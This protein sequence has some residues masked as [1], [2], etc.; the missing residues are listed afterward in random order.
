ML[1]G[2]GDDDTAT[3]P[4][5]AP[6]PPPPP[7]APEPEP[8]PEPPAPEAPATPTGLIVS[9][10]SETSITW[11]WD[12]VEGATAYAV[13]ASA[14]EMFDATD[15]VHVVLMPTFTASDL[16]PETSVFVRVAAA[17]GTL[18]DHILSAWT[19]HVTGMSAMPPPEPEP[20]PEALDPVMVTFSL[21]MG[22]S[23]FLVGIAGDDDAATAM[24]MVNSKIMVMS[25]TDALI[26]P[27][28]VE[29]ANAVR[30]A[31]SEEME[32]GEETEEM[33]EM[34]DATNT[35]F[36]FVSWQ[37]LQQKVVDEGATFKITRLTMGANQ[38][39][40][41]TGDSA[42]LTCGPF[43]CADGM[44]R[45]DLALADSGICNDWEHEIRLDVGFVDNTVVNPEA[46]DAGDPTLDDGIDVGWT[47]MSNTD[48]EVTHHF[49]GTFMVEAKAKEKSR[50]TALTVSGGG[51]ALLHPAK[52]NNAEGT[53]GETLDSLFGGA[54]TIGP[55][56]WA[57]DSL[58]ATTETDALGSD[59]NPANLSVTKPDGCFRISAN[60]VNYLADYSIELAAAG[61]AVS[62]GTVDWTKVYEEGANPFMD[63]TCDTVMVAAA[64]EVDV[65][66]L[67]EDEVDRALEAGWGGANVYLEGDDSDFVVTTTGTEA[68]TADVGGDAELNWEVESASKPRQFGTIWYD[69]DGDPA[70]D[71]GPGVDLYADTPD[72]AA[73][74]GG[75]PDTPVRDGL[76][77]ALLDDDGD[78]LHGDIGKVD[79]RKPN[80]AS[81]PVK[82]QAAGSDGK[83]DNYA[84]GNEAC[85]DD[86]G[87]DGCDAKMLIP[88]DYTFKSGTA[89]ECEA[90]RTVMVECTWDAQGQLSIATGIP[91]TDQLTALNLGAFLSCKVPE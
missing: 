59:Y 32:M 83:A 40:E 16:P 22:E 68:A 10:T 86:D 35:P 69:N 89:F 50:M 47:Y 23:H 45:P 21:P 85:S 36:A 46:D 11:T 30:V 81:P 3:T 19:T 55:E 41:P 28:F 9:E 39:M 75:E 57:C 78:P 49:G 13:Q 63:L 8:E 88:L 42:Y 61:S 67:F 14:D 74:T 15:M 54:L 70:T 79:R 33:P 65:C 80:T 82:N 34:A 56:R 71:R 53:G 7:P 6:P 18:E 62:W 27:M 73:A 58:G 84:D 17:V 37:L 1:S 48:L 5:P 12:A 24:A 2:C 66:A 51:P 64:D 38:E 90:D 20:E 25:N 31:K 60:G 76:I 26:E 43:N 29:N 72:G 91:A 77:L 4:A 52:E 87:G 44:D